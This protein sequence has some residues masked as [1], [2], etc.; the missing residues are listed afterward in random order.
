MHTSHTRNSR[1]LIL[2]MYL[3][4]CFLVLPL[5]EKYNRNVTA[6]C[7]RME[8]SKATWNWGHLFRIAP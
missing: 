1:D 6:L 7:A 8:A 3:I 4:G 2:P 5:K